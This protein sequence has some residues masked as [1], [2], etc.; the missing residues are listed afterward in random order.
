MAF[1]NT[2]GNV[3]ECLVPANLL[4]FAFSTFARALQRIKDAIGSVI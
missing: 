3:I 2:S 4:P 1:A